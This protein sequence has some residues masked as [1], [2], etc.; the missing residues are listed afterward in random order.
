MGKSLAKKK[1]CKVSRKD[2]ESNYKEYTELT[3]DPEHICKKCKRTARLEKNLCKP[4]KL[5]PKPAGEKTEAQPK[6]ERGADGK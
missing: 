3:N 5:N 1:L 2:I 6:P 4:K